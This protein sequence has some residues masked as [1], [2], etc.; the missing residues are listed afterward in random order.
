MSGWPNR[1]SP[2]RKTA[3]STIPTA[4]AANVCSLPQPASAAW[5]NQVTPTMPAV[6]VTAPNT[7][8]LP[9]PR[10]GWSMHRTVS[11]MIT[12]PTGTFT[13]ITQRQEAQEVSMP[14]TSRPM[15]PPAEEAAVW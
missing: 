3:S 7:S 13:S 5:M 2:T 11:A 14:P 8:S 4:K 6:P 10:G 1:P 12:I 15:Q 9:W